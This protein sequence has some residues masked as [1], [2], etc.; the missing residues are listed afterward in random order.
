MILVISILHINN[1]FPTR[2]YKDDKMV[3]TIQLFAYLSNDEFNNI[4]SRYNIINTTYYNFSKH[5]STAGVNIEIKKVK[6][7]MVK[8]W[9]FY[10]H[11]CRCN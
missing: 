9:I 5:Y 7:Y 6:T 10:I 3:H 11:I 8:R 4:A 1:I 2:Y